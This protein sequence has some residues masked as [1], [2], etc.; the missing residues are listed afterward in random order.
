[1]PTV[2]RRDRGRNDGERRDG[3]RVDRKVIGLRGR[4]HAVCNGDRG[5][6]RAAYGRRAAIVSVVPVAMPSASPA[7]RPVWLHVNGP[8]AVVEAT[9][10]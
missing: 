4:T 3:G 7:G 10:V 2:P 5:C 8:V 1:M 6:R 9:S